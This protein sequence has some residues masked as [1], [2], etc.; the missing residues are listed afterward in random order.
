MDR[1]PNRED[2]KQQATALI[3]EA[4]VVTD[5]LTDEEARPLIAWA[6]SQAA[7]ATFAAAEDLAALPAREARGMLAE[8][9]APVRRCMR[10]INALAGRR[11]TLAPEALLEEL[12]ALRAAAQQVPAPPGAAVPDTALAELAAWQGRLDTRAF[13]GAI[14]YLLRPVAAEDLPA[15]P[16]MEDEGRSW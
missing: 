10:A 5:E 12:Q 2:L 3:L 15:A 11:G 4:S 9:L 7:A 8:R 14:L 13:V 6:V 1:E 16:N